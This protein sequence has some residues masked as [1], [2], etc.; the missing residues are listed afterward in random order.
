MQHRRAGSQSLVEA[1]WLVRAGPRASSCFKCVGQQKIAVGRAGNTQGEEVLGKSSASAKNGRKKCCLLCGSW[2][3]R[4]QT[5]SSF[6]AAVLENG[7]APA[8]L[9]LA[10]MAQP[11]PWRSEAVAVAGRQ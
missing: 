3:G 7:S 2:S 8:G 1:A 5:C 4:P 11:G 6:G 9:T 10:P